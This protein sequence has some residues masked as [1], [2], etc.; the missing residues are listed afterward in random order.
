MDVVFLMSIAWL[1]SGLKLSFEHNSARKNL[2]L[3]ACR[4]WFDRTSSD[5][6]EQKFIFGAVIG[7]GDSYLELSI[8]HFKLFRLHAKLFDAAGIVRAFSRKGF[9]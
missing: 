3:N 6:K 4:R 2:F 1:Y 7:C 8:R 9:V 5:E